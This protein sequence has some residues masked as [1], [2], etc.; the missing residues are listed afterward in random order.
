MVHCQACGITARNYGITFHR[1]PKN[2]NKKCAWIDF[3]KK[4]KGL[5]E[6]QNFKCTTL[7]SQHFEESCFDKTSAMKVRLK[8]FSV[9]TIHVSRSKYLVSVDI[10]IALLLTNVMETIS[11][12]MQQC[13]CKVKVP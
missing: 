1:F 8:P 3:V 9:P 12:I 2:E 7:C 6:G 10:V 11:D 13:K 4:H 5:H